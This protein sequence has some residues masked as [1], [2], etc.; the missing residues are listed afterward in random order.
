RKYYAKEALFENSK[1]VTSVYASGF[2]GE[3]DNMMINKI[4][5]D[6]IKPAEISE[7]QQPTYVNVMKNAIN[8]SDAVVIGSQTIPKELEDFLKNINKPVLK[9]HNMDEF[10]D[11]YMDF[12][13]TKVLG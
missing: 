3:L 13:A 9:F 5:F 8:F 11:A 4:S 7:L 10:S 2:E 1:I 12:Y 6:G